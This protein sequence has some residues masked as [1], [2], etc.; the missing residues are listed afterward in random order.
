MSKK[1]QKT[2]KRNFTKT[3]ENKKKVPLENNYIHFCNCRLLLWLCKRFY[4][5]CF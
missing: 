1:K 2:N 5:I 3:T 4:H